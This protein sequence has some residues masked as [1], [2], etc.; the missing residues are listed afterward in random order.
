MRGIKLRISMA[1]VLGWR[2]RKVYRIGRNDRIVLQ[3]T[4]AIS[5]EF[6]LLPS[7]M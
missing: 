1:E 3:A 4:Y 5:N 2:Y 6:Y 7:G